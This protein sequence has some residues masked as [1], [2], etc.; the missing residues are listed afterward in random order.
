MR[1]IVFVFIVLLTMMGTVFS[2]PQEPAK[3][4][5]GMKLDEKLT[6]ALDMEF[7]KIP[8]G[9]FQMGITENDAA[10]L[11]Q[12]RLVDWPLGDWLKA[13]SLDVADLYRVNGRYPRWN[14]VALVALVLGVLPN[15]PGFLKSTHVIEG[16]ATF[17]DD[18]YVYAWFTGFF[19]AFA[20]YFAGMRA[21][22]PRAA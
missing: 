11:I 14:P 21:W 6:N 8:A 3:Q 15:V 4:A 19:V 13:V 20:V 12:R 9:D 16:E 2:E 1:H 18:L 5:K 10:R 7:A 22:R 17:F